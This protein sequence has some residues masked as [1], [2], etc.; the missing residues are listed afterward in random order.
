MSASRFQPKARHLV[1]VQ[2][3]M[4]LPDGTLRHRGGMSEVVDDN[5]HVRRKW[6][7]ESGTYKPGKPYKQTDE[8]RLCAMVAVGLSALTHGKRLTFT[9]KRGSEV[10]GVP[11]SWDHDNP[12]PSK[13]SEKKGRSSVRFHMADG[14]CIH[15]EDCKA[16]EAHP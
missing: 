12:I 8:T 2:D 5:G 16:V 15:I 3:D 10:T 6:R 1:S 4:R 14:N 13:P 7:T 9:L 11:V